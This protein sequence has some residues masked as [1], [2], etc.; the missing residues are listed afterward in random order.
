MEKFFKKIDELQDLLKAFKAS[1]A[2]PKL[3]PVKAAAPKGAPKL[4]SSTG[5]ASKKDPK[6]VAEQIKNA[7]QQK[8]K[9]KIAKNGQWSM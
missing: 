6:K 5:P 9:I 3:A 8:P 4:P 2:S 1:I 7:K